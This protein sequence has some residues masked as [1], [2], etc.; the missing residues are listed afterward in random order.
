M[1]SA[2][3]DGHVGGGGIVFEVFWLVFGILAG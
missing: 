3:V 2:N 1:D